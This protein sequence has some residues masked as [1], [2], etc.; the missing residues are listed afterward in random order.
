MATTILIKGESRSAEVAVDKVTTS[1]DRGSTSAKGYA[2]SQGQVDRSLKGTTASATTAA[3][4]VGKVGTVTTLMSGKA[5]T[6]ATA[7]I[8]LGGAFGVMGS[9]VASVVAAMGPWGLAIAGIGIAL[10]TA[11]TIYKNFASAADDVSDSH[12]KA[13]DSVNRF[14]SALNQAT[15]NRTRARNENRAE[16]E[17]F[18]KTLAD[19]KTERLKI[20]L[21]RTAL[22]E[23]GNDEV[24][25]SERLKKLEIER[26]GLLRQGAR[27]TGGTRREKDARRLAEE[28]IFAIDVKSAALL[29]RRTELQQKAALAADKARAEETAGMV[30]RAGVRDKLEAQDLAAQKAK[31]KLLK[32]QK[33]ARVSALVALQQEVKVTA[34]AAKADAGTGDS[35]TVRGGGGGLQG[36]IGAFFAQAGFN[37]GGPRAPRGPAQ[38]RGGGGPGGTLK[39]LFNRPDRKEI[40]KQVVR[41]RVAGGADEDDARKAAFRGGDKRQG[42]ATGKE[43]AEAQQQL[44]NAEIDRVAKRAG[45]DAEIVLAQKKQIEA[46][47]ELNTQQSEMSTKLA[48]VQAAAD[49]ILNNARGRRQRS[50]R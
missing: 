10:A 19:E 12:E 1:M 42:D 7:I 26:Q 24:K 6:A 31:L 18:R 23:V 30:A 34:D 22:L 40:L 11:V 37:F 36:G 47:A 8:G 27:S 28:G 15:Q 32:D 13:T 33:D 20:K 5:G 39:G 25:T 49:A 4:A 43:I 21:V 48:Q 29:K 41:S 16:A 14:G 2:V 17:V 9:S 45:T 50:G 35:E 46:M 38:S 44:A 3:A